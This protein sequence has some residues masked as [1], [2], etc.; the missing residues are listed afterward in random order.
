[1]RTGESHTGIFSSVVIFPSKA[2]FAAGISNTRPEIM[3]TQTG[4]S[5]RPGTLNEILS[6]RVAS[7]G[8]LSE[9]Q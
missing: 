1:M 7:V 8:A 3:S 9:Y 2:T 4:R 6:K 5:I